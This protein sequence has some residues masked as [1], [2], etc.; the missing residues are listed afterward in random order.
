MVAAV[1]IVLIEHG[2]LIVAEVDRARL[3]ARVRLRSGRCLGKS[4]VRLLD[5]RRRRCLLRWRGR[6]CETRGT[7]GA[8]GVGA[9]AGRVRSHGGYTMEGGC[10]LRVLFTVT[11]LG[12][13]NYGRLLA[14]LGGIGSDGDINGRGGSSDGDGSR[15][16]AVAAAARNT[17]SVSRADL[18]GDCC[19]GGMLL[20]AAR[21]SCRLASGF[22]LGAGDGHSLLGG[23]VD[24][25]RDDGSPRTG[26]NG[27]GQGLGGDEV[28]GRCGHAWRQGGVHL[29]GIDGQ[30]GLFCGNGRV[31]TGEMRVP[32]RRVAR[33][34]GSQH[35]DSSN[36]GLHLRDVCCD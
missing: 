23:G 11:V 1:D 6:R 17:G 18:G 26:A 27:H 35:A 14:N 22:S 32:E 7:S 16:P 33:D 34:S 21:A 2:L 3:G 13:A 36:N 5:N 9:V 19:S 10:R 12:L 29:G 8:A 15:A 20:L 31:C 28:S 4:R 25:S 24:S 30:G